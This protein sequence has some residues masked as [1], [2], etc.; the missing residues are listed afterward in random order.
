MITQGGSCWPDG[1]KRAAAKELARLW[2]VESS[3]GDWE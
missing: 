2:G 3:D 1:M